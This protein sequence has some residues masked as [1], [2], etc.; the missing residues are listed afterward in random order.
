MPTELATKADF[1]AAISG[2]AK[3]AV[4]FYATWCG[5]CRT[6]SPKF[7]GFEK[8]FTNIK[9]FK[10]DVDK[11]EDTSSDCKISAMPTFHFYKD[12][13]NLMN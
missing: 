12:G 11:N 7:E 13:K 9:F 1:D 5:P 10:V 4:D 3:V 2:N 6:I 8:E